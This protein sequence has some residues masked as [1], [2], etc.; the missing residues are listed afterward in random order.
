M[1][2]ERQWS[3]RWLRLAAV[4]VMM[5]ATIG[6]WE[7][8]KGVTRY[9]HADEFADHMDCYDV[10]PEGNGKGEIEGEVIARVLLKDQF[11]NVSSP[12][13]KVFYVKHLRLLCTGAIKT[14]L[15]PHK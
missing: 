15:P 5:L 8:I 11:I 1:A 7:V 10:Y 12:T 4:V 2:T 9:A 13:G 3:R 6:A 14:V